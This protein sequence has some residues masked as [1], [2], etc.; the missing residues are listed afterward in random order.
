MI[1]YGFHGD[2]NI[3][4]PCLLRSEEFNRS[5][6]KDALFF[7]PTFPWNTV[8]KILKMK[9]QLCQIGRS[10]REW[11][12]YRNATLTRTKDLL[13]KHFVIRFQFLQFTSACWLQRRSCSEWNPSPKIISHFPHNEWGRSVFL[14]LSVFELSTSSWQTATGRV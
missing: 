13:D 6:G 4:T 12:T 5:V 11:I 3:F 8:M 14:R 9:S 2:N 7:I 1:E 10:C